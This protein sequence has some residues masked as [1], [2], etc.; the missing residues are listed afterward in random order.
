MES[1]RACAREITRDHKLVRYASQEM[2]KEEGTEEEKEE[3]C[4]EGR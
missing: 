2:K 4:G 3:E 1:A